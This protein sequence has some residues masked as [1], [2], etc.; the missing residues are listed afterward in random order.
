MGVDAPGLLLVPAGQ[1]RRPGGRGGRGGGGARGP[2]AP[3]GEAGGAREP[4]APR[5]NS[6]AAGR[7]AFWHSAARRT[8]DF[9]HAYRKMVLKMTRRQLVALP[10]DPRC[11]FS[12][13]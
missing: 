12:S 4:G 11:F 10:A 7:G 9:R 1:A 3:A 13:T 5:G 6:P 8:G 2:G